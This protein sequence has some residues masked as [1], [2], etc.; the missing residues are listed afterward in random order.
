VSDRTCKRFN[1]LV[2]AIGAALE[3]QPVASKPYWTNYV[4][5]KLRRI[6]DKTKSQTK[7]PRFITAEQTQ[8]A[9]QACARLKKWDDKK[10][11][12]SRNPVQFIREEIP[13]P[14][15]QGIL[16][17]VVVGRLSQRLYYA[18]MAWVRAHP[19]DDLKLKRYRASD[20]VADV[21]NYKRR[22][23]RAAR[24]KR[25]SRAVLDRLAL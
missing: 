25:E 16:T 9:V 24:A 23:Y 6:F 10:Y 8:E 12:R 22:Q 1:A 18:Y 4:E 3:E 17:R 7:S 2:Y 21:P 13:G 20:Y 15:N 19:D 5:K 11:R 14:L